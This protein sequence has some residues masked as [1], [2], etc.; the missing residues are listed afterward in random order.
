MDPEPLAKWEQNEKESTAQKFGRE[1]A[2][3]FT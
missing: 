2:R 3:T 1:R